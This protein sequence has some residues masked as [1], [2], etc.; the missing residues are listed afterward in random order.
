MQMQSSSITIWRNPITHKIHSFICAII[1]LQEVRGG[2]EEQMEAM[3]KMRGAE[4]AMLPG[5][6][7]QFSIHCIKHDRGGPRGGPNLTPLHNLSFLS[8]TLSTDDWFLRQTL[9]IHLHV[10]KYVIIN[11]YLVA[12]QLVLYIVVNLG[13]KKIK[14]TVI[15]AIIQ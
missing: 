1:I 10:Y 14:Y 11:Q 8:I 15:S 12:M 4:T 9:L 2:G 3:N 5:S 7:H 6:C 13:E